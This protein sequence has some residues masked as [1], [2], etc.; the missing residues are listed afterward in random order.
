MS[1][2]WITVAA[3]IANFLVLIWLLK[4]FLYRPILD[5][6][7]AREAAISDRMSEAARIR[8]GAE[9]AEAEY[10]AQIARLRA[11]REGMM[12]EARV[13][14]QA[15]RDALLAEARTRLMREQAARA[16]EREAEARRYSADLHRTGAA[17]LLALTRK[18]LADLSGETLEERIVARAAPRLAEMSGDLAA[19]AG[20]SRT[21]VVTT[22]DALPQEV[23]DRL[24]AELAP[25]IPWID[26]EFRTDAAHSPGLTLRLGG[27]QLGWTVDN[28]VDGLGALLNREAGK[29]VSGRADAA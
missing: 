6:I 8:E 24:A 10:K 13:A 2:D 11:G 20:D 19:A 28:Y 15:E 22:R 23:R 3:Q 18:A 27:A 4:R 25:V 9:A 17:A 12:D 26:V 21:A 5:G 29:A 16:E 14:A 1:I 7:D